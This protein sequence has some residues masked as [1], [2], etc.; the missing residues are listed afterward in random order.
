MAL[1]QVF[2]AT[3]PSVNFIL[4]NGKP[5]I[6]VNGV[7]RTDVDTEAAELDQE[8]KLGHPHIRRPLIE[9]ER[10]IESEMVDPM[11]ALRASI[12]KEF[13]AKQAAATDINNDMGKT[14][15]TSVKPANSQDVASAMAGGSGAQLVSRLAT[16]T[17]APQ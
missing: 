3:L 7:F 6:F 8:I 17:S 11:N 1:L 9:A 4:K 14:E 13:L 16:I 15:Q 5:I 10:T 12:I 2:Q